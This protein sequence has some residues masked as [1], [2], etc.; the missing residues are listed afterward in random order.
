MQLR[1]EPLCRPCTEA[2]FTVQATIVDHIVPLSEGGSNSFDNLDSLCIMH[3]NKK[4][5]SERGN[6]EDRGPVGAPGRVRRGGSR[7]AP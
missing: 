4:T 1:R 7:V 5:A 6:N 2:G 3:H